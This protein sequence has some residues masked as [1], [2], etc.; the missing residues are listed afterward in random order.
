MRA[1]GYMY[2]RVSACTGCEEI[3]YSIE[4]NRMAASP[5]SDLD[6]RRRRAVPPGGGM[7]KR[8]GGLCG[9][10]LAAPART[11]APFSRPNVQSAP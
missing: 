6:P 11:S 3:S 5:I 10:D 9:G 8:H 2:K 4:V 1:I 7:E